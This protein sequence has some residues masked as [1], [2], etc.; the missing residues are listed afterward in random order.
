MGWLA[1]RSPPHYLL[2]V[3]SLSLSKYS[4]T[5]SLY[6]CLCICVWVWEP[7]CVCVLSVTLS[8]STFPCSL[9]FPVDLVLSGRHL[10][11]IGLGGIDTHTH[12]RAHTYACTCQ[13]T[14]THTHTITHTPV[15]FTCPIQMNGMIYSHY[16]ASQQLWIWPPAMASELRFNDSKKLIL[17]A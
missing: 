16:Y 3:G 12:K 1:E 11:V 7:V 8:L 15:H 4:V 14:N 5:V 17:I 6:V 9:T 13:N 2:A 10:S